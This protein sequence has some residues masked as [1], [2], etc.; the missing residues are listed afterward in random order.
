MRRLKDGWLRTY[1][2]YTENQESPK[3]F[4]FWT[5]LSVMGAALRRRV[6]INREFYTIYPNLYTILVATSATCKKSISTEI[7]IN[8][9]R[10]IKDI[11]IFNERM[12]TEGLIDFFST[13]HQEKIGSTT[14]TDS[15]G[16][17]YAD[18]LSVFLSKMVFAQ[19]IIPILT[20]LYLGK[21]KWE[22]K[23]VKRGIINIVNI[24]PSLL[25][26]TT[27]ES[28]ADCIPVNAIGLGFT[29][30]IMFVVEKSS[31]K[32]VPWPSKKPNLEKELINDLYHISRLYGEM[33]ISQETMDFYSNWYMNYVPNESI[34]HLLGYYQRKPDHI[35]KIAMLLSV[36]YSDSLEIEIPHIKAAISLLESLEENM[37]LAFQYVGTENS[38]LSQEILDFLVKKGKPVQQQ[39][40]VAR[41]RSKIRTLEDLSGVLNILKN[42]E[43]IKVLV[44]NGIVWYSLA[45]EM[46]KV[47]DS[48][49][50]VEVLD[51]GKG[52]GKEKKTT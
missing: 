46:P 16:L 33:K 6:W 39:E 37:P 7:G 43:V 40:L 47:K 26:S 25:S 12:S 27:P 29:G 14:I 23:T 49:G 30:R 21:T 28:L 41:F 44:H 22:Y 9:L 52:K 20:S 24:S 1:L 48:V 31:G 18:E 15:S 50:L 13:P 8:M 42:M 35:L 11:H 17:I 51:E 4:H 3:T 38:A 36:N 19:D 32:K 2:E 34:P 45:K 10:K 5:G